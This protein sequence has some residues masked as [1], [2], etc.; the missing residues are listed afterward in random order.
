ME[1]SWVGWQRRFPVRCV[2]YLRVSTK[3]QQVEKDLAEEGFSISGQR[4]ACV[5]RI[6]DEGWELIDEHV[7][8]ASRPGPLTAIA[9]SDAGPDRRRWRCR[10]CRRP[11]GRP[12]G[13]EY[14]RPH[15]HPGPLASPRRRPRLGDRDLDE[16]AS[17][18]LVEGIHALMAEFYSANLAAEVRKGMGQ[19][20]KLGGYPHKAPSAT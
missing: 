4:E 7:E 8:R 1:V 6:R 10:G 3:E 15:R 16:T 11:Q 12:A 19:K 5:R 18:R 9:S 20:A 17:G 13:E 14:G 2:I